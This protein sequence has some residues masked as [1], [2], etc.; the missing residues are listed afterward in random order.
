M[1]QIGN[2]WYI[3]RHISAARKVLGTHCYMPQIVFLK[4]GIRNFRSKKTFVHCAN[5][6]DSSFNELV[7]DAFG[8]TVKS[9]GVN[10]FIK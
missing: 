7:I 3:Y 1:L 10:R 8:I 2:R 4:L 5:K 9:D 6:I